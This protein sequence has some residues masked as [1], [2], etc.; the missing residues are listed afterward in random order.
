MGLLSALTGGSKTSST[1]TTNSQGTDFD[2]R[3]GLNLSQSTQGSQASSFG[4]SGSSA[5]DSIYGGQQPFLD[6][7]FS[8]ANDLYSNYGMPDKQVAGLN[9]MLSQ[10][11]AQQYGFS[12]GTG[13]DITMA[14]LASS[15]GNLGGFGTAASAA[16][17]MAGGN[18]FGSPTVDDANYRGAA[19]LASMGG[20]SQAQFSRDP[21]LAFS[22]RLAGNAAFSGGAQAGLDMG[23][24]GAIANNPYLDGQIDAASRDVV[25]NLQENQLTGNAALAASTGNSGSSRRAVMDAVAQR[26]A[27]DRVADISAGMRGQAYSQGI[28]TAAEQAA[29]NA[30]LRQGN[31]QYNSGAFNQLLGQGASLEAQRAA[32]N[33]QLGTQNSQFNTGQF[34]NLLGQGAGFSQ[35]QAL[36]NAGLRQQTQSLNANMMGQGANLAASLGQAG[37]AGLG[38]A[39]QTGLANA[40]AAQGAGDFVRQYQQ[41]VLDTA[42]SNQMNP[43]TGLQLY[44]SFLGGPIKMSASDS[45]SNQGSQSTS[46]SQ[47]TGVGYDMGIGFGQNSSNSTMKSKGSSS[48][49]LLGGLGSLASGI[50]AVGAAGVFCWVAREVYGEDNPR[51]LEFREWM[52][53]R[54]PTWFFDLYAKHGEAFAEWLKDKPVIKALIRKWMDGRIASLEIEYAAV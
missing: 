51:W 9:P 27:A 45:F 38:Q 49:G 39:F 18:V 12:Q 26:G 1:Q 46:G 2:Y 7:L 42:F 8:R 6:A 35:N 31:Q 43:Y 3:T 11:L 47:S 32:Q 44:Q 29:L 13:Q 14:Q 36:Q 50:G 53:S 16:N 34:N 22:N 24:A 19:E 30:N 17:R 33:A 23:L 4:T 54:A 5:R 52:L 25:R 21:S 15:L 48:G 10:G 41:Q 20:M 37:Q 40:Q 28:S